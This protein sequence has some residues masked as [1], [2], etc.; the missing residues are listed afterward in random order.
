A[1]SSIRRRLPPPLRRPR[2]MAQAGPGAERVKTEVEGWYDLYCD[3]EAGARQCRDICRILQGK[4]REIKFE[5]PLSIVTC[6]E[7]QLTGF[8]DEGSCGSRLRP[9]FVRAL[10]AQGVNLGE[11][12]SAWFRQLL[13]STLNEDDLL[14]RILQVANERRDEHL[15]YEHRNMNR[16][17]YAVGMI[18]A[19]DT[20]GSPFGEFAVASDIQRLEEELRFSLRPVYEPR[21]SFRE[22]RE[23]QPRQGRRPLI[24]SGSGISPG[25]LSGDPD[26]T[27]PQPDPESAVPNTLNRPPSG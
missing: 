20:P 26:G 4:C 1:G 25:D 11:D 6:I 27:G 22:L 3:I 17:Y 2:A 8:Y 19:G 5:D 18:F 9:W 23:R 24:R 15:D 7:E 12:Q 16:A 13:N 21:S 10:Q 14:F